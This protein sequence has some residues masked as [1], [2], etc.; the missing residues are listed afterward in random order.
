[1]K[2]IRRFKKI[3]VEF[4]SLRKRRAARK[5]AVLFC[6][7]SCGVKCIGKDTSTGTFFPL[8]LAG[9]QSFNIG[10]TLKISFSRSD[11]LFARMRMHGF[12]TFPSVSTTHSTYIFS[13]GNF[14]PFGNWMLSRRART[15]SRSPLLYLAISSVTII[16]FIPSMLS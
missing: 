7:Y 15:I 9:V 4:G 3:S 1:M 6:A 12:R 16:T 2:V 11:I 8:C 13:N 14:S 5:S 10:T